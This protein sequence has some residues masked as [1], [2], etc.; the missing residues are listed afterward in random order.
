MGG[1]HLEIPAHD[2]AEPACGSYRLLQRVINVDPAKYA[3]LDSIIQSKLVPALFDMDEIQAKFDWVFS[4][5][6]KDAGLGILSPTAEGV[7]NHKTLLASTQHLEHGWTMNKGQREGKKHKSEKYNHIFS[8]VCTPLS[9]DQQQGLKERAK[10]GGEWLNMIPRYK[11]NNVLGEGE[12]HDGLLMRKKFGI[13]HALDC[14][15]GGLI[16]V[17]HDEL[18]DKLCM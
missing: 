13:H 11:N 15:S 14:K 8:Q 6:V 1:I 4:L 9:P 5:L 18:W 16:T 17:R 3:V 7:M 12:F 10:E 2:K